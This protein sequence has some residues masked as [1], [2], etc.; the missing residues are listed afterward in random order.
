MR[1]NLT[2]EEI[3]RLLNEGWNFHVKPVSKYMY[4]I[5]RRGQST[6][7]HGAFNDDY[8]KRIM[9]VKKRWIKEPKEDAPARKQ[10]ELGI[11]DV[12]RRKKKTLK[13]LERNFLQA[14]N[15]Q[16]AIHMLIDCRYRN[17]G[18]CTRWKFS[19][20]DLT[21]EHMRKY[22]DFFEDFSKFTRK[23]V[24]DEEYFFYR[25]YAMFC[26]NCCAYESHE[27]P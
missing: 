11:D 5:T 7:S 24:D 26:E 2:D 25:A 10:N 18:F 22:H 4:I 27:L 19:K 9:D 21:Y 15:I 12:R 17:E 13:M 14:L 3:L 23:C 8:W 6:L 1:N 16:R 20:K